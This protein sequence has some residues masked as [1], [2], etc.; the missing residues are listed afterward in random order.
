MQVAIPSDADQT[1]AP[2]CVSFGRAPWFAIFD[3]MRN[4]LKF[5]KNN[6][7]ESQGGAGIKAAQEVLDQGAEAVIS[8][9]LGQN[10]ADVFTAA[11]VGIYEAQAGSVEK[12]IELFRAGKLKSLSDFHPGNHG[13][14]SL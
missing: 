10:A 3:T 13:Q 1:E 2:V 7:A 14:K 8:P 5:V 12:N 6:A 11:K 9:R 4:T